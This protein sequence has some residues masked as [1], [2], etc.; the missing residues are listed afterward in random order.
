[1]EFGATPQD[2]FEQHHIKRGLLLLERRNYDA[3]QKE[4]QAA[5]VEN[6]DDS[7]ARALLANCMVGLG[8]ANEA[9]D[10]VEKAIASSPQDYFA[11]YIRSVVQLAR[12]NLQEARSS[13]DEALKLEPYSDVLYGQ[14]ASILIIQ[15]KYKEGLEVAEI[16]LGIN[17]DEEMCINSR[18][19][20]LLS[21]G[22]GEEAENSLNNALRNDPDNSYTHS[23][24]GWVLLRHGSAEES[25][26]HFKE[27]LRLD[28]ND[29][30]ARE[31][32]VESLKS[33]NP[34]YHFLLKGT[35]WFKDLHPAIRVVLVI[36]FVFFPV[37]RAICVIL[38]IP[39]L[40]SD[41]VF[42]TVLRFDSFGKVVLTDEQ[43][44]SNNIFIGT[45][46][47]L[48]LL[49]IVAILFPEL[50]GSL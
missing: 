13:C 23:N 37:V 49:V 21:L 36:V 18:A 27:A 4:F 6:P 39:I 28:P 43:I 11:H 30:F 47:F 20:A 8:K 35:L 34:I 2:W 41:Q 42:N 10:E 25:M 40:L 50:K 14:L 29:Q 15:E 1:M 9:L 3:A 32:V 5:I 38:L 7:Y 46:I 16:G 48:G 17:P 19:R 33:R 31:G 22:K 45:I 44:K 26:A 12:G 24:L